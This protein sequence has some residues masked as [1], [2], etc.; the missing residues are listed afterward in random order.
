MPVPIG[1]TIVGA[2]C[3]AF[4]RFLSVLGILWLPY[5]L[6][7]VVAAIVLKLVSPET[8]LLDS[9]AS[10]RANLG[11]IGILA[12]FLIINAM[13]TV[14]VMREALSPVPRRIY[15]YFSLGLPV[16]RMLIATLAS[17]AIVYSV[18]YVALAV[19][20][21]MISMMALHLPSIALVWGEI[22]IWGLATLGIVYVIARLLFFLPAVVVAEGRIGI[23]RSWKLG[24]HNVWRA[25]FVGAAVYAPVPAAFAPMASVLTTGSP[26]AA[27]DWNMLQQ[28][29]QEYLHHIQPPGLLGILL[30]IAY[31]VLVFGLPNGAAAC[32]YRSVALQDPASPAH[33]TSSAEGSQ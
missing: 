26:R 4:G 8:P 20:R 16:W 18:R 21:V 3:F 2:Y 22:L 1:K 27:F 29:F 24:F 9:N 12:C 30:Q 5:A 6:L 14:G 13:V 33:L 19:A 31:L 28:S 25:I 23:G 11:A 10:A 7:L 32:A 17:A 15:S